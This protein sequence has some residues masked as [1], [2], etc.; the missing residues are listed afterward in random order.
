MAGGIHA[1]DR[2]ADTAFRYR[3]QRELTTGMAATVEIRRASGSRLSSVVA[4][5]EDGQ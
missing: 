3:D 2:R 1:N 4:A 5:Y